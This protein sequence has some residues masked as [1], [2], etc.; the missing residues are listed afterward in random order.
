MTDPNFDL[1]C[2]KVKAIITDKGGALCHAAIIA[3]EFRIPCIVGCKTAT[4]EITDGTLL[5]VN[6]NTGEVTWVTE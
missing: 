5:T 4:K 3:R 6:A 1:A 2:R